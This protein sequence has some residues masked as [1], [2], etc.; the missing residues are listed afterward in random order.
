MKR[1]QWALPSTITFFHCLHSDVLCTWKDRS[2][3]VE[4]MTGV[5]APSPSEFD[6][7]KSWAEWGTSSDA[8]G[9]VFGIGRER[10]TM[11][12][13]SRCEYVQAAA[14]KSNELQRLGATTS[15]RCLHKLRNDVQT[16]VEEG[17]HHMSS[18][19][20]TCDMWKLRSQRSQGM[21]RGMSRNLEGEK[22]HGT[23]PGPQEK[24]LSTLRVQISETHW[25][26]NEERID[27]AWQCAFWVFLELSLRTDFIFQIAAIEWNSLSP[28]RGI[29]ANDATVARQM[30]Y[31][32]W[33]EWA[34]DD[35]I[36]AHLMSIWNPFVFQSFSD[37]FPICIRAWTSL[38]LLPATCSAL[39]SVLAKLRLKSLSFHVGPCLMFLWEIWDY[40]HTRSMSNVVRYYMPYCHNFLPKT[41]G[42][43]ETGQSSLSPRSAKWSKL[44][45]MCG[46]TLELWFQAKQL[47]V[48]LIHLIQHFC[49]D[50]SDSAFDGVLMWLMCY[51]W[52]YMVFI[53]ADQ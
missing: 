51:I 20:F 41:Q 39:V 6:R 7:L 2:G 27:N 49:A 11:L 1:Q 22:M 14:W 34:S 46:T 23:W 36:W 35:V 4:M 24:Q 5:W 30:V 42:W 19:D 17:S 53:L 12:L 16:S 38:S 8:T 31:R 15:L 29:A 43:M 45:L 50:S 33:P 37:H 3:S 10:V 13:C 44:R 25:K 21:S 28:W 32:L 9:D 52:I 26:L 18:H 40:T 47:G 48:P